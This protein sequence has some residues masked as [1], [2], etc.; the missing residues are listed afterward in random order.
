M[1]TATPDAWFRGKSASTAS[2]VQAAEVRGDKLHG[3]LVSVTMASCRR[4]R[5]RLPLLHSGHARLRR[6]SHAA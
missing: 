6:F 2:H 4:S 1:R 5:G 3:Y